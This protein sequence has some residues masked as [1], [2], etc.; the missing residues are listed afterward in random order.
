MSLVDAQTQWLQAQNVTLF[1]RKFQIYSELREKIIRLQVDTKKM[2]LEVDAKYRQYAFL[3][4][5]S[6]CRCRKIKTFKG[7]E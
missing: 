2:P 3:H 7:E 5:S 4:T 1:Q 6:S